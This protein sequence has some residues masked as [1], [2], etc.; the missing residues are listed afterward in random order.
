MP[1]QS[2]FHWLD[3][4]GWLIFSGGADDDVRALAL[5]RLAADGGIACVSFADDPDRLLDDL[6]D[7]GAPPAYVVDVFGE[8][9]DETIQNRLAQ[10]G[11]IVVEGG[12]SAV[13]VR[14]ALRGA[15]LDGMQ[16]AFENGA[17][18]LFEGEAAAAFGAWLVWDEAVEA[19]L[20][21]LIGAVV[22]AGVRDAAPYA[23]PV[24]DTQ[25]TAVAVAI[26]PG[27]ALAFGPE[28]EIEPWGAREVTVALGSAY[29]T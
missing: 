7:L 14:G 6:A 19:G 3:G 2:V 24:L 27:S 13:E 5:A 25:P 15:A 11:M 16:A 1:S 21:W 18:M 4:R 28:G 29:G 17:V 26:L 23:K 20:E 8:D 22:L 10:A 9:D 12:E